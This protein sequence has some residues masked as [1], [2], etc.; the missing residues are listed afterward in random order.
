MVSPSLWVGDFGVV[1]WLVVSFFFLFFF[2]FF[3]S[4]ATEACPTCRVYVAG[5]CVCVKLSLS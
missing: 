4:E 2:F 5:E 3:L 1:G